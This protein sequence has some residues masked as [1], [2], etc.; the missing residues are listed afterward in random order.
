MTVTFEPDHLGEVAAIMR[1]KRRRA[2]MSAE[3][4]AK[5]VKAGEAHRF[6]PRPHGANRSG[7]ALNCDERAA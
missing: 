6:K 3:R 7:M 5:L 4:R 2:A 1:P